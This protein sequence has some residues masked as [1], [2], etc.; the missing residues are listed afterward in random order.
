MI[1]SKPNREQDEACIVA[2]A[3]GLD[4]VV[5]CLKT[6]LPLQDLLIRILDSW[7]LTTSG[8]P[9]PYLY[10]MP[11]IPEDSSNK[12]YNALH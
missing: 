5:L 11:H 9:T 8:Q 2:E 12:I 1:L 4:P 10:S 3:L 7:I 6:S